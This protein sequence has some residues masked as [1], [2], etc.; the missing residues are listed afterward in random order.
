MKVGIIGAGN[1]GATLAFSL[2]NKNICSEIILKDIREDIVEAMA[3]DISQAANAINSQTKVKFA[4]KK[5]D[6]NGCDII[7]IT[8]GIARKPG[9]SRDDLLLTNAKIVRMVVDETLPYNKN[10]IFIIISNPLDAMVYAALKASG[11]PRNKVL[12]MAGVLDSSRMAHFIQ[13]KLGYAQGEIEAWVMGGHGDDMV[14]LVNHSLVAGKK[15][16]DLLEPQDIDEIVQ[17]TR[18]GGAQI[19]GLLKTGSAYYAPANSAS[20]MIEAILK[21]TKQAMPCSLLLQGEYGY[22][23]VVAGVPLILGKN[24]AEEIV[25][26][27]LS[28]EQKEQFS[29][30]INSVKELIRVLD[31]NF[32]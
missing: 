3:L 14:P 9:M 15:L 12:G 18:N 26:F 30:S 31:E 28:K 2:M 4:L 7:V 13:E 27:E 22:N 6:L 1:V 10:A 19:V 24:G 32:K 16:S 11:L 21:D 20:L 5:E 23:D 25:Q 29:K 17:K 8:A